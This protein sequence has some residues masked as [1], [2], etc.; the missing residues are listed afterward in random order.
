EVTLAHQPNHGKSDLARLCSQ[1]SCVVFQCTLQC[2]LAGGF[3]YHLLHRTKYR[4]QIFSNFTHS[5]KAHNTKKAHNQQLNIPSTALGE[6]QAEHP[7]T[8][9]AAINPLNLL[10]RQMA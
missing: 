9:H 7:G 2:E 6:N 3:F 8:N 5:R 1:Y 4:N 10:S